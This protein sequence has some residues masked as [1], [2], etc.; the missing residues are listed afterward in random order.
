MGGVFM[1]ELFAATT[2]GPTVTSYDT[3]TAVSQIFN[4]HEFVVLP[5]K[6]F[7]I[8]IVS[9]IP[10]LLTALCILLTGWIVGRIL[11]FIVSVVLCRTGFNKFASKIGILE[12]LEE[13]EIK[14]SIHHWIG[15]LTFW[16]VIFVSLMLALD[17]LPLKISSTPAE[18]LLHFVFTVIAV[19]IILVFGIFL[20]MFFAKVVRTMAQNKNVQNSRLYG[21]LVRWVV[22]VVT[23]FVCMMQIGV[24]STIILS[25]LSIITVT[26][27]I[28][29][30]LAFGLGGRAWAAKVL[31]KTLKDQK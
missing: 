2:E 9:F 25:V 23:V 21:N 11:Q 1:F 6:D 7:F 16:V 20:S 28:A 22:L 14:M 29:F 24:M 17:Q 19:F 12:F 30:I 18:N 4:W 27:C 13:N 15:R 5:L 10:Y 8:G 31:D 3:A 26:I